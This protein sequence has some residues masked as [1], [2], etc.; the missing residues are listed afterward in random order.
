MKSPE[1]SAK[2]RTYVTSNVSPTQ[3]EREQVTALYAAVRACLGGKCYLVG[4]YA[5]FTASRPMHDVDVLF[6]AGEFNPNRLDPMGILDRVHRDLKVN[7]RNPTPYKLA[8]SKQTHS[9]T[10]C[11]LEADQERFAI[12]IVP[13]LTSGLKNEFQDDIYWVPEI[14]SVSRRNRRSQYERL[15]KAAKREAEWWIKSDPRGYVSAATRLNAENADYRRASKL[16]KKWKHNCKSSNEGFALKSFHVEQAI[17]EIIQRDVRLSMFDILFRFFCDL[18]DIIDLPQIPDRADAMKF[19]DDYV[20]DFS[21]DQLRIILE[22][23]DF[24]L[25]QLENV[26]EQ[27]KVSDVVQGGL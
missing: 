17:V 20:K 14:L 8:I 16:V 21:A 3:A 5:R 26:S 19:I 6:V 4:S 18:P 22:A 11:F 10:I 27:S 23:R 9:I 12:D 2:L 7:F 13:A 24:L 15:A 1:L 25:I